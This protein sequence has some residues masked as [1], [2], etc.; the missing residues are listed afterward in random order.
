MGELCSTIADDHNLKEQHLQWM[1]RTSK[2]YL[3]ALEPYQ[4]RILVALYNRGLLPSFI[5][6]KKKYRFLNVLECE[7]HLERTIQA[8]KNKV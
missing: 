4:N 2:W 7:A 8:L 5:T 6:K 1:N 3:L